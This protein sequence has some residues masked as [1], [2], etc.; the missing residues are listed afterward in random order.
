MTKIGYKQ[1][2][3]FY[4]K[5]IN[6]YGISPRGVH[7][8]SQESQYKRFEV[9]TKF[10]KEDISNCSILDAGCGFGE[11]Y[12]YLYDNNLKPKEYIGIDCEEEMISLALKR[13]LNIEFYVN[14]ILE[15][16]LLEADYYICS[17]AMNI[18]TEEEV[19]LFI[20]RSYNSAK[21]GFIFNFLKQDSFNNVSINSVLSFCKTLSKQINI[22]DNYLENDISIFLKK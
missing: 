13:F 15:D 20:E 21:K 4:K 14:N 9:L 10:I 1:N 5:V 6:K 11:Y 19:F 2:K 3:E 16:E 7:W 18:L 22:K 12:N 8:N 17:G